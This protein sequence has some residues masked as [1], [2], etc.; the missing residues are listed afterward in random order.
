MRTIVSKVAV[1]DSGEHQ[2]LVEDGVDA[3]LVGLNTDDTVLRE[4]PR[5]VSEETD[6]LENILDDDWL[7]HVQLRNKFINQYHIVSQKP[8]QRTS[9]CPFEPAMLTTV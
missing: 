4:R 2:R 5:A 9:N 8:M 6:A 3:L 7:E 1:E